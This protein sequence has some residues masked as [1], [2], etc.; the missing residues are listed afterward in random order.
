MH[1]EEKWLDPK[2]RDRPVVFLS[3]SASGFSVLSSFE[4]LG[5]LR[6]FVVSFLVR[7]LKPATP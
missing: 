1:Q 7:T 5:A 4:P 6:V 3:Q 2:G